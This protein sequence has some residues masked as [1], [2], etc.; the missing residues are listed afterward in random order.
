MVNKRKSRRKVK[1]IEKLE[2]K[3]KKKKKKK[4]KNG[5]E[6]VKANPKKI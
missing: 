1:E 5:G 6:K 4:K 3:K 2:V